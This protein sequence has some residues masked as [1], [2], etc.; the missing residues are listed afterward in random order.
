MASSDRI[1]ARYLQAFKFENKEKKEHKVDRFLKE[2]RD[3]TGISKS[4]AAD[5][6]DAYVR[7]REVN[8]LAIQKG[9]PL[10]DFVVTGPEGTFDLRK[11]K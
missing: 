3:A 6:A 5:I 11:L 1:I 4:Q 9:W 8:R 7:G 10:E 2:L